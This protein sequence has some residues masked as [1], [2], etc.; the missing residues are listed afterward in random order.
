MP[1]ATSFE[2]A[3]FAILASGSGADA[4][5]RRI[6]FSV[7][8]KVKS[9]GTCAACML[10]VLTEMSNLDCLPALPGLGLPPCA[11]VSIGLAE[12][13]DLAASRFDI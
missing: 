11:C 7:S 1:E 13:D 8:G 4:G 10:C 2:L 6:C 9:P 3:P 12:A 5:D